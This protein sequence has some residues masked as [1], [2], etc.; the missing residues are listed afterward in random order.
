[1]EFPGCIVWDPVVEASTVILMDEIDI[2]TNNFH[3]GLGE[4]ILHLHQVIEEFM[5]GRGRC[6]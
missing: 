6:I 2:G 1:M 3:A 5:G 4:D